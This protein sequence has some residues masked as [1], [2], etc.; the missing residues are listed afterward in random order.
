MYSWKFQFKGREQVS[1][2]ETELCF[3][4]LPL[5]CLNYAIHNVHIFISV[6]KLQDILILSVLSPEDTQWRGSNRGVE[7]T[8]I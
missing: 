2:K 3:A 1:V 7:E 4:S 5:L 8:T 6:F